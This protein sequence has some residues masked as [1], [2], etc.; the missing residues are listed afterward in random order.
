M[1]APLIHLSDSARQAL[2][3]AARDAGGQPLRI[4]I[5]DGFEYNFSFGAAAPGDLEVDCD[6]FRIV[7]DAPSAQRAD[8]L[9]IDFVSGPGGAGLTL[10][11]PNEP[12]RVKQLSATELKEMMIRSMAFEL[13][14]VR[15]EKERAMASIAGSRLLDHE[16][17][18]YLLGLDRD[19]T[20]VFHC[21]L[22]GRSQS[23]AEY[24]RQQGFR[25]LFN[26]QGGIDAWSQLVDPSV[27]RY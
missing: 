13:I 1:R 6:G 15:T 2:E 7:L 10:E 9:R 25:N 27:P 4:Q 17:H 11:N 19:A 20:I 3:S 5:S 22:G 12:P 16:T 14:D 18:D 24:F 21:H 8:G 23:A 26:L